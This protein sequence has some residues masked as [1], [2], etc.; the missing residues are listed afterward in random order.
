MGALATR[1][2]SGPACIT[3]LHALHNALLLRRSRQLAGLVAE[4]ERK[5]AL[6]AA[7]RAVVAEAQRAQREGRL[8]SRQEIDQIRCAPAGGRGGRRVAEQREGVLQQSAGTLAALVSSCWPCLRTS[9]HTPHP[10]PPHPHPPPTHPPCHPPPTARPRLCSRD[11]LSPPK[12]VE[13][14]KA[15]PAAAAAAGGLAGLFAKRAPAQV[16]EVSSAASAAARLQAAAVSNPAVHV[17]RRDAVPSGRP[18][19]AALAC[20]RRPHSPR[21]PALPLA[22]PACLCLPGGGGGGGGGGGRPRQ[23]ARLWP[24]WLWP[25]GG[26]GRG[27]GAPSCPAPCSWQHPPACASPAPPLVL[28]AFA[29]ATARCR[30]Q[31]ACLPCV[32]AVAAAA[33]VGRPD[34]AAGAARRTHART[35]H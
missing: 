6:A 24:V 17:C 23:E 19:A 10:P 8:L 15:A 5:A 7:A 29:A 11:V 12:P 3:H 2:R 21:P 35:A 27:G 22:F 34:A 14:P 28:G 4:A 9:L 30:R 18:H 31:P 20:R 1:P 33:F 16:V 25:Q 26:R 32:R 13:Q